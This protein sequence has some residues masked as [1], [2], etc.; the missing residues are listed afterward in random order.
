MVLFLV[1]SG[2][3]C[4]GVILMFNS[5][6]T[7]N[8]KVQLTNTA[9]AA[10][11]SVAVQQAR[12][13]NFAAYMNRGRIANEVAVAQLV[14]LMSWMNMFHTHTVVGHNFFTYLSVIPYVGVVARFLAQL[15]NVAERVMAGARTVYRPV[16]STAIGALDELNGFL[17]TAADAMLQ[18]GASVD[19][20]AIARDVVQK[21]D[22]T[23][24]IA[25]LGYGLLV[26]QLRNAA[27]STLLDRFKKPTGK[28]RVAGMD[29]FRNVVMA[30]RDHFSADREDGTGM[31]FIDIKERGGTD[32]VDYNRWVAVDTIDLKVEV[33]LG[34]FE[35][36]WNIPLGFGGA[37]AVE[38]RN[39][40]PKFFPGI[41]SG[42]NGTGNGWYS[43]YH[44]SNTV[45][46][47]YGTATHSTARL[48]EKYPSVNAPG[49][50]PFF[51]PKRPSSGPNKKKDAYFYGYEG[52][53]SYHDVKAEY[54]KTP[55]GDK[56]GPI[57]TVF[58]Q[59]DRKDART[60][61]DIDGIGGPAGGQ[62]E[63]NNQMSGNKMTA[64]ASAQVYF[65]RPPSHAL[66]KRMVPRSWKGQD[67]PKED[68]QLEMG[69]LFSPYW[70]ARLVETPKKDYIAV[71]LAS[72]VAGG[73]P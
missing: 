54:G 45:Y 59:S 22:P 57:F 32:L 27:D 7:V 9:D 41:R 43:E 46:E 30:S 4:L 39:S 19:G 20:I 10:A 36:K 28:R 6:Q 56:A 69:S 61:Q 70:Q 5:G 11:Y 31:P 72:L 1:L 35:L 14:S 38:K 51:T 68:G 64:I 67:D 42:R 24:E 26:L 60:S 18:I 23:A 25:P 53:R 44:P 15:Y 55:E 71:G 50:L 13:M 73:A 65:N 29:R 21:N 3:L 48:A 66:F 17:A 37:Q 34:L 58:V 33:D 16:A 40:Q 8:K 49:S 12:A 2:I 52:L 62:L 63:L 47:Q